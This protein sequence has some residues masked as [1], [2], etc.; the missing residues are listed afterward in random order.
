MKDTRVYLLYIRDAVIQ[1]ESYTEG[2]HEKFF[3]NK[4]GPRRGHS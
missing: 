2:G 1:I 3:N 4:Y